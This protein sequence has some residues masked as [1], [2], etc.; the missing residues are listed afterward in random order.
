M[1][2]KLCAGPEVVKNDPN[3]C[4]SNEKLFID[5][6]KKIPQLTVVN[7]LDLCQGLITRRRITTK[8][9]EESILDYFVVCDRMLIFLER[10]II[11]EEKKF[12]R[13]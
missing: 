13:L 5:F 2:G 3:P 1:D 9:T 11:D 6:L 7:S 10:M 4:N 12:V 8:R